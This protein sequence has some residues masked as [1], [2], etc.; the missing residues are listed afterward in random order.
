MTKFDDRPVCVAPLSVPPDYSKRNYI[1][2]FGK[3]NLFRLFYE[4][5]ISFYLLCSIDKQNV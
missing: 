5:D 2:H 3:L 1:R 4:F